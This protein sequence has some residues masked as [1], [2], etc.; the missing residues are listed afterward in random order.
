MANLLYKFVRG[1]E[2]DKSSS[3]E[4]YH[5]Y[6]SKIV[7]RRAVSYECVHTIW[8]HFLRWNHQKQELVYFDGR[9]DRGF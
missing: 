9:E 5:F 2:I 8:R 6:D 7:H 1:A 3:C 4:L